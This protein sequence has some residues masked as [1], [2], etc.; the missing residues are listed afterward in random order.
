MMTDPKYDVGQTVEARHKGGKV[1]GR[2]VGY[3]DGADLRD[4][5]N[6][7]VYFLEVDDAEQW[8]KVP[9]RSISKVVPGGAG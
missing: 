8:I 7:W 9:E 5:P 4:F 6:G 3:E 2:I 1:R